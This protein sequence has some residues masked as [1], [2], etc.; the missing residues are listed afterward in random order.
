MK[1]NLL[2]LLA[3]LILFAGCFNFLPDNNKNN[4]YE[5]PPPP[6]SPLNVINLTEDAWAEGNIPASNGEQWFKF[7]IQSA[8]YPSCIHIDF[9]TL[10]DLNIQM[11][12]SDGS[13]QDVP[14]N[15]S[16]D[17]NINKWYDLTSW[18]TYYLKV[19]PNTGG[20]T[21]L[22]TFNSTDTAPVLPE[23]FPS[24][25]TVLS[26][27][28]WADGNIP[29][30][31]GEQWFKFTATASVQYIHFVFNTLQSIDI[32]LFSGKGYKFGSRTNV[33]GL[34]EYVKNTPREDLTVGQEYYIQVLPAY[35]PDSGT[36]RIAFNASETE[37]VITVTL[38]SNAARLAVGSW[39]DAN[40]PESMEDQWFRFTA[41]DAAHYLHFNIADSLYLLS[42]G[43]YFQLYDSV[44][45]AIGNYPTSP[46]NLITGQEYYLKIL[47]FIG[48]GQFQIAVTASSTKPP[49]PVPLPTDAINLTAGIWSTDIS[50]GEQWFKFAAT[51]ADQYLHFDF[52][53]INNAGIQVYDSGGIIV[54]TPSYMA[55][56]DSV[57]YTSRTLT[58]GQ[59]YYIKV[60]AYNNGY[61]T[62]QT[63]FNDSPST[64]TTAILPA[65]AAL[66]IPDNWIIIT[67][68]PQWFKF[69]AGEGINGDNPLNILHVREANTATGHLV[70]QLYE[71]NGEK[72]D[73]QRVIDRN[74][75]SWSQ[76]QLVPGQE[77][78]LKL[79]GDS[80]RGS[81]KIAYSNKSFLPITPVIQLQWDTWVNG[82]VD[83]YGE[84]WFR[85][86]ANS[87]QY[88]Y[89]HIIFGTL[90]DLRV[91]VYDISDTRIT[92]PGGSEILSSGLNHD[93]LKSINPTLY[94]GNEY[95]IKITPYSAHSTSL[96]GGTFQIKYN[97]SVIANLKPPP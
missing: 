38:P 55:K 33:N 17:I 63:A 77:Y 6:F 86:R 32:Q 97:R 46:W 57:K 5:P 74:S 85:F 80:G 7:T 90:V 67:A 8:Y 87:Q 61:G 89:I 73:S 52:G 76:A 16:G 42:L 11:Y 91:Q 43:I 44:G 49:I 64:P 12:K 68:N 37:P 47:T 79:W 88:Q 50:T 58:P 39:T 14:K 20:G 81:Y 1:K 10:T 72:R 3:S 2:F 21:Y 30:E 92:V 69:T 24:D 54:G 51:A 95:Y 71:G 19:T 25:A 56:T 29:A 78:Y 35:S 4:G 94:E 82:N 62:Y 28:T 93:D 13:T 70:A 36:Y 34:R 18:E 41:T 83:E 48:S 66:L 53:A 31:N 15:Y 60:T 96:P 59:E 27:N 26:E 45:N 84:Q 65:N 40:M 23:K 75:A 9:G 22:I